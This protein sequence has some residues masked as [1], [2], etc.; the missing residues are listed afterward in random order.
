MTY[1]HRYHRKQIF[2]KEWN[3]SEHTSLKI[4]LITIVIVLSLLQFTLKQWILFVESD[5]L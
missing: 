1:N 3:Q 2:T 5:K 4:I